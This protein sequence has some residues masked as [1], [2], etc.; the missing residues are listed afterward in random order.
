MQEV[1]ENDPRSIR[2]SI[3][4]HLTIGVALILLLNC[5]IGG[6]AAATDIAGALISPG[7]V[8]SASYA[9]K[10][11]HPSGGV[12][13]HILVQND[14]RVKTGDLLIRLDDTVLKAN[15]AVVTKGLDQLRGRKARLQ[16]ER[17]RSDT[18]EFTPELVARMEESAVKEITRAESRLFAVRK[19]ARDGQR[20][21]LRERIG[22]LNEQ[23]N[24]LLAQQ[25]AKD[26]EGL[27]IAK[28]ADNARRLWD[29]KIIE[30]NRLNTLE[31]DVV[32]TR[33]EHAQ[34]SSAIAAAKVKISEIELQIIQIDEDLASEVAGE[35]REI[36]GKIGEL[37]EREIAEADQLKRIDIRA[38][39]DGYVHE[40][41]VHTVGGVIAPGDVLMQIVPVDDLLAV[42]ARIK[43]QDIDQMH[44]SQGASLRFSAFSQRT[45]PEIKGMVQSISPDV[46]TDTRTGA[47]Y[48]SVRIAISGAELARLGNVAIVP[49]MPVEAF[50]QTGERSAASYLIKP[51]YDQMMRA[52]RES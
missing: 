18:I 10:V 36:D 14:A 30:F 39:Q 35:I 27:L 46:S 4:R 48:Y 23:I 28:E 3:R 41:T 47:S 13:S 50:I 44:L 12:V 15:L 22:Q 24:G 26:E 37:E 42:D 25:N 9:K 5:G 51:F 34:L 11:Q 7:M 20:S 2:K 6:W 29:Q 17:D 19:A 21:Q 31:R 16:A 52:F 1:K 45:T 8:V 40:L 49:G 38:P 33:G 32:R 43:P